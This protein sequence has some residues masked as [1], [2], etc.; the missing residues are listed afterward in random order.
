[1]KPRPLSES[2]RSLIDLRGRIYREW[3]RRLGPDGDAYPDDFAEVVA[4][5]TAFADPLLAGQIV[6]ADWDPVA[7]SWRR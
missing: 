5:V 4:E 2:I 6:G 3:R 1:M 7:R